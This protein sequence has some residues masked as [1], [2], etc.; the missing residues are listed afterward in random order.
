[1]ASPT[2]PVIAHAIRWFEE[3]R[4][5]VT[6]TCCLSSTASFL[7]PQYLRAGFDLLEAHPDAEFVVSVTSYAFPVLRALKIN[8]DSTPG[9]FWPEHNLTRSRIL[10][11][12]WHDA[13]QFY[14]GRKAAFLSQSGFFLARAYP[15][16]LPR[17]LVQDIDTPED[18]ERA[19]LMFRALHKLGCSAPDQPKHA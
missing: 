7:Q 4:G 11:P 18:W 6:C 1:M 3:H 14:W 2:V 17:H 5:P 19:E 13:G 8:P 15:V 12:A 10:P 16:I 9:M